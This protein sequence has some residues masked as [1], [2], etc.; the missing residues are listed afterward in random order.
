[1]GGTVPIGGGTVPLVVCLVRGPK[2]GGVPT[3]GRRCTH[4]GLFGP[5]TKEMSQN[6]DFITKCRFYHKMWILSQ[7]VVYLDR[8]PKRVGECTPLYLRVGECTPLYPRVGFVWPM[9]QRT[10]KTGDFD[11]KTGDFDHKMACFMAKLRSKW[12]YF[13]PKWLFF[14]FW[15]SWQWAGCPGSGGTGVGKPRH[16][17]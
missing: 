12:L 15:L 17:V 5:W 8:G 2:G 6:V 16:G 10:H 1:M 9:D 14:V 13:R 3:V 7:N 4:G 11:H